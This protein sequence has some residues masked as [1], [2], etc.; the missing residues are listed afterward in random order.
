MFIYVEPCATYAEDEISSHIHRI[1]SGY[2]QDPSVL[3]GKRVFLKVNGL[4]KASP[5]QA[6]TTHP[7]IVYHVADWLVK[8]GCHVTIGDNPAG[9]HEDSWLHAVYRTTGFAEAADRSGAELTFDR[10]PV[11]KAANGEL[12]TEFQVC[13]MAAEADYVIDIA[14]CKTHEYTRYTGC[15]KNFYGTLPAAERSALHA[16][17]K[18]IDEFS[19][20][21]VDLCECIAPTLSILDAVVGME[22]SG[23]SAG[24]PRSIGVLIASDN[25]HDADYVGARIIGMQVEEVKT[26]ENASRRGLLRACGDPRVEEKIALL[27]VK[28]FKMP[29]NAANALSNRLPKPIYEFLRKRMKQYPKFR[30][31]QCISCGICVKNCPQKALT[32][33]GK[34][35][36]CKEKCI[37]CYCCQEMCPQGA[38]DL[39]ETLTSKALTAA[40]KLYKRFR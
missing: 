22:G 21:L 18:D 39:H 25:P 6:M 11:T 15:V 7:S 20:M 5:E 29:Q 19:D 27:C 16:R 2:F 31:D 9:E 32:M 40:R 4:T 10:T 34:P 8:N 24:E 33:N 3:V 37:C 12:C 30:K 26:L 14:K 38:V 36:F 13:R 28:N 17:Y 1:L 23:P 35:V